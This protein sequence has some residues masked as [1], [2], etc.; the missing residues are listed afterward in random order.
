MWMKGLIT[1]A[2][3]AACLAGGLG[4][5]G[6]GC[7][8]YRDLVDPCWPERYA[9]Q[10]RQEVYAG[11]S[12]QAENG[13][14][15]DQTIWNYHFQT[16]EKTGL[17]T[18]KL[19]PA[20]MQHLAYIVRRRPCPDSKVYVQTAQDIAYDPAIPDQFCN[21]RTELDAR[22]VQAVQKYLNAQACGRPMAFEVTVH[23]P[24]EVGLPAAAASRAAQLMINNFQ[25]I[26]PAAS[27]GTG[28]SGAT[29]G[30]TAGSLPAR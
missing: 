18:D 4:V 14:V 19:T 17:P 5:G 26:M 30:T 22:R 16:D 11:F 25:G 24:S 10:A 9:H 7:C 23:D 6:G 12:P 13:H 27:A 20:A 3:A 15:L 21:T 29:A 1:R 2:L 28:F 8:T